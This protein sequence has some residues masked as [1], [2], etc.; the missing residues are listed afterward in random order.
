MEEGRFSQYSSGY[1][2]GQLKML[3]ALLTRMVARRWNEQEAREAIDDSLLEGDSYLRAPGEFRGVKLPRRR[4]LPTDCS[5]PH[6]GLRVEALLSR[7]AEHTDGDIGDLRMK[8]FKSPSYWA[9]N[10][11][12]LLPALNELS[13]HWSIMTEPELH[14]TAKGLTAVVQEY[15]ALAQRR[16]ALAAK[17]EAGLYSLRPKVQTAVRNFLRRLAEDKRKHV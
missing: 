12:I 14:E 2:P 7:E 17:L 4:R 16:A 8:C 11:D 13:A 5:C 9:A 15:A 10:A 6:C 1:T 3:N